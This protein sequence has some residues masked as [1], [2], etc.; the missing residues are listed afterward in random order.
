MLRI[1]FIDDD[2]GVLDAHVQYLRDRDDFDWDIKT[3]SNGEKAIALLEQEEFDLI[4]LDLKMPGK[5][6]LELLHEIKRK[7]EKTKV[8]IF[9]GYLYQFSIPDLIREG[10]DEVLQKPSSPE[11]IIQMIKRLTLPQEYEPTTIVINGFNIKKVKAQ[12]LSTL[13][14][15]VLRK[16]NRNV[17]AAAELMNVSR[18]CLIQM[19]KKYGIDQ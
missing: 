17:S 15:K 10:A 11:P 16:T 13:I 8:V 5:T 4:F 2:E 19:M 14:Q 12:V 18:D 3:A 7:F 6:G 1:L 9:S